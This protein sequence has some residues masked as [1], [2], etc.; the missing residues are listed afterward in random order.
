MIGILSVFAQ[1]EKDQITERLSMGRN[2]RGKSGLYHGGS[3]SPFGYDYV[4]GHL[5]VNHYQAL[6]V[7]EV[8][9]R[10]L[11][12]QSIN[13]IHIQM[14]SLYGGF[15]S[16]TKV[17]NMLRNSIYIGKGNEVEAVKLFLTSNDEGSGGARA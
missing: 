3:Q 10:F 14:K 2:A 4:D 1:L 6:Q 15:W 7:Q 9:Q 11:K 8:F 17:L 13:S 12:G 16:A 5:H